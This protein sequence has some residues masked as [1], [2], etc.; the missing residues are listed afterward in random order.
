MSLPEYELDHVVGGTA[1][2]VTGSGF[3]VTEQAS[4]WLVQVTA[5]ADSQISAWE[6]RA[7]ST[8]VTGSLVGT[9]ADGAFSVQKDSYP[10]GGTFLVRPSLVVGG[11]ADLTLTVTVTPARAVASVTGLAWRIAEP[12]LVWT[13]DA[14]AGADRYRVT[15]SVLGVASEMTVT[16][17]TVSVA[18]PRGPSMMRV[19]AVDASG[20]ESAPVEEELTAAVGSY[21]Y[22]EVVRIALPISSGRAVN[23]CTPSGTQ[24][25]RPSV[26]GTT[27]ALPISGENDCDL[28]SFVEDLAALGPVS[29]YAS[30][31]ASWFKDG[32]WKNRAGWFESGQCDLGAAYSGYVNFSLTQSLVN[33]GLGAVSDYASTHTQYLSE[34]TAEQLMDARAFVVV[35]ILVSADAVTWREVV[36]GQ[37]VSGIRYAKVFVQVGEASPLTE[38]L[39][40][41]GSMWLDV[42]DIAEG[43]TTANVGTAYVNVPLAKKYSVIKSVLATARGTAKAEVGTPYASGSVWYVPVKV[44]A[45]TATVDWFVKGY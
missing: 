23:L 9:A 33:Y 41:A 37:W 21:A 11:Y 12:D 31:P 32:W 5:I 45:G 29:G 39:V 30:T 40:T 35:Q 19:R 2:V 17:P 3:T 7:G 43:G 15:W 34:F 25:R 16:S 44:S 6:M 20:Q 4:S 18:I 1:S 22:N 36:N 27:P 10:S 38:I 28:Y 13:W 8:W 42:P 26:L 14:V 24:I